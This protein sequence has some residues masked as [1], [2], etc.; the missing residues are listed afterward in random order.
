MMRNTQEERQIFAGGRQTSRKPNCL[1]TF[2]N[3]V[4]LSRVSHF[5]INLV[6]D[7]DPDPGKSNK[8]DFREI[9]IYDRRH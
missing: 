6:P 9:Y 2:G 1:N 3:Q 8:M 5:D 4:N 7:I